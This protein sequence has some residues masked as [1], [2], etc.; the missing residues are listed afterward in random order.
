[1]RSIANTGVPEVFL[2]EADGL[3]EDSLLKAFKSTCGMAT[4]SRVGFG[5][6]VQSS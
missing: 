5:V 3:D 6:L 1:M 2:V 4:F